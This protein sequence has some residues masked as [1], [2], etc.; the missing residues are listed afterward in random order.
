MLPPD[1]PQ[2]NGSSASVKDASDNSQTQQ[3]TK[4][5]KKD[6]KNAEEPGT[7]YMVFEYVS[8]DLTGLILSPLT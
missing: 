7:I 6:E 1:S 4:L 5:S 2:E 8:Y 3:S